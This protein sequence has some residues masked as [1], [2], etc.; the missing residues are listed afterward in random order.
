M[1]KPILVAGLDPGTTTGLCLLDFEGKIVFLSSSKELSFGDII[2][3]T[4]SFG[5]P[6]IVGSDRKHAPELVMRYA[7][8]FGARVVLPDHDLLIEEKKAIVA[9]KTRNS[10]E[11]DCLASARHALKQ[12][13]P[14]LTKIKSFVAKNRKQRYF[15]DIASMVIR[16]GIPIKVASDLLEKPFKE[17]AKI[18]ARA[19]QQETISKERVLNLYETLKRERNSAQQLRKENQRLEE[20]AKV[21][22]SLA[23]YLKAKMQR[24]V[25]DEKAERL[26]HYRRDQIQGL[27]MKI[28]SM[29]NEIQ[30]LKSELQK[31]QAMLAD[32]RD[33][34]VLKKLKNLGLQEFEKKE[35]FL[36]IRE[37]D[38]LL[39]E[40]PTIVSEKVKKRLSIL[41]ALILSRKSTSGTISACRLQLSE[42][43]DFALADRKTL[44][45]EIACQGLLHK[46]I[47]DYKESRVS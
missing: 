19:M 20:E 11:F 28:S 39:V 44:E 6:V 17:E 1:Q 43:R 5:R 38:C 2:D 23:K 13:E 21:T 7:T 16:E 37:G 18:V 25:S 34:V 9:E 26:L 40:D 47:K 24:T 35:K 33:K 22:Q 3:K 29:A 27:G 46:V 31:N 4:L 8:K 45:E 15:S 10:H 42:T 12:T 36:K 14:L 32:C 30:E 41:G